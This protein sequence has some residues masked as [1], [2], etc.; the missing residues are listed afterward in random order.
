MGSTGQ[1]NLSGAFPVWADLWIAPF[2][3]TLLTNERSRKQ[4]RTSRP[5]WFQ[6]FCVL[7][8]EKGT[9]DRYMGGQE[10]AAL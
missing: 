10:I 4:E 9:E 5:L 3:N 2:T 1:E 6:G 8:W 7:C